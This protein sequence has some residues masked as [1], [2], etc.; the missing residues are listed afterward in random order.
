MKIDRLK[1]IKHSWQ[2][3]LSDS[4]DHTHIG[5]Q[6]QRQAS[7][8]EGKKSTGGNEDSFNRYDQTS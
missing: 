1:V 7:I 4:T 8:G 3:Q 2:N 5:V 6:F